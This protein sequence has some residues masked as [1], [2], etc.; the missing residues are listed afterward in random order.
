MAK[1]DQEMEIQKQ[2]E[3][4][5]EEMERTRSRR[6]FIPRADIYE[7]ENEIIVL[8]DIPG[9]STP[10]LSRSSLPGM[11]WCTP[12]MKRAITSAVSACQTR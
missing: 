3:A 11:S 10:M 7:T 4:P 8:T 9:A 2:E 12:S 6:S 1:K 5:V